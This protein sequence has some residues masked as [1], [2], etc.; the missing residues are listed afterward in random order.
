MPIMS[1][2]KSPDIKWITY[3][4]PE[5]PVTETPDKFISSNEVELSFET[6][7]KISEAMKRVA[8][9][10]YSLFRD[11]S[12]MT[13]IQDQNF[14]FAIVDSTAPPLL[15]LPYRL[16]IP[17]AS[18]QLDFYPLQ[19]RIP[20]FPSYVPQLLT[21]FS[22][23]MTFRERLVNFLVAYAFPALHLVIGDSGLKDTAQFAPHCPATDYYYLQQNA[24][25]FF[26]L[27]APGLHF[28][29]GSLPNM[30]D[31]GGIMGEPANA[32][33]VPS[34]LKTIVDNNE[35]IMVS[36]GSWMD[37]PKETVQKFIQ[38][39]G[40]SNLTVVWRLKETP[41]GLPSNVKTMH[42]LPQND[43]LGH[44]N[45]R[46]FITHCGGSS[47]LETAFHGIPVIG[48]PLGFD[49]KGNAELLKYRQLGIIM[50][51]RKFEVSELIEAIE[52]VTNQGSVYS[53]SAK[54]M[55]A[56]L[57]GMPEAGKTASFWIDHVLQHGGGHLR[58]AAFDLQ[59]Y[60]YL[61]LDVIAFLSGALLMSVIS[62][63][64]C[65]QCICKRI[66]TRK[67]KKD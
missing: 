5:P 41:T 17:Y 13:Q 37:Q 2:F 3:K 10:C 46:A 27:R 59:W 16:G 56:I 57:K 39:F 63:K 25:L 54:R 18:F 35:F 19:M 51:I 42:W 58:S 29:R 4:M 50:D 52:L 22:D 65:C 48:F 67:A 47:S 60:E 43:L 9:E 49:Q 36:F 33:N 20:V 7:R 55:S 62:I 30:V 24:S 38:A 26:T 6:L 34:A 53:K 45:I 66:C 28:V 21:G 40:S 8:A 44:P 31:M 1:Q 64:M 61:S 32:S 12:M 15:I 23:C 14:D 11:E